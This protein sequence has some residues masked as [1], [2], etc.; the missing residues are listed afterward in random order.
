MMKQKV[1]LALLRGVN[2]SGK[3]LKMP[4]LKS[5]LEQ[6]GFKQV[7]TYIQSGNVLFTHSEQDPAKLS[8][9]VTGVIRENFGMDVPAIMA[10]EAYLRE[11]FEN[12]PFLNGRNED[13]TRLYVTFL[14]DVPTSSLVDALDRQKY[15]PEEFETGTRVLYFYSPLGYGNARMNNNFF[16]NKLKL[17][18]TTRNWKSVSEL[19]KMLGEMNV[20]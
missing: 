17:T 13:I 15:L 8:A 4:A 6:A 3:M 18:A 9:A 2:V 5:A 16:E 20:Q 12:N 14:A 11:V 19:L 10:D 7:K 1:W